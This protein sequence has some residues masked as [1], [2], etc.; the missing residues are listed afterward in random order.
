MN[1]EEAI[2]A[3]LRELERREAELHN[4]LERCVPPVDQHRHDLQLVRAERARLDID[5]GGAPP[6]AGTPGN[7]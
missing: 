6:V 7:R 3:R 4:L 2:E 5:P 1:R